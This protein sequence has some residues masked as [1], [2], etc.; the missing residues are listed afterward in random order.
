MSLILGICYHLSAN[1]DWQ[2]VKQVTWK[3]KINISRKWL[4]QVLQI[5]ELSLQPRDQ[6][7]A[8]HLEGNGCHS[9]GHG[10]PDVHL[11]PGILLPNNP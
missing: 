3:Q 2:V 1:E 9:T 7:R 5:T 4:W 10:L 6:I 11:P 8:S